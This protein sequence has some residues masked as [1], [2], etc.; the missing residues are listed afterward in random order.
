MQLSGCGFQGYKV[1]GPVRDQAIPTL[2]PAGCRFS[3][4]PERRSPAK[5]ASEARK[6]S[7]ESRSPPRSSPPSG[8]LVSCVVQDRFGSGCICWTGQE[9]CS[10][11]LSPT[12]VW[13]VVPVELASRCEV[14]HQDSEHLALR[15]YRPTGPVLTRAQLSVS[16]VFKS[17]FYAQ[18]ALLLLEEYRNK[19]N[20]TED[21]QLRRSIQRVIDIFQSNLFQALIGNPDLGISAVFQ[22]FTGPRVYRT[23]SVPVGFV[24]NDL[25]QHGWMR[26]DLLKLFA[27]MSAAVCSKAQV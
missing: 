24:C 15:S 21:R 20:H 6:C 13:E 26:L 22:L 2:L 10:V 9:V 17:V 8:I 11:N 19:L 5:G 1:C 4:Q 27:V 12:P 25:I 23:G 14:N 3:G 16:N 18:R 7:S